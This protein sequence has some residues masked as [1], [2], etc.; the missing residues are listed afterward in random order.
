M[1]TGGIPARL[2]LSTLVTRHSCIVGSTGSGKSN[3]VAVAL[4]EL[5]DGFPSARVLVVDPHGEYGAAAGRPARVIRTGASGAENRL[6]VPYWALP[7]DELIE[8]TMGGMQPRTLCDRVREMKLEA[9]QQ[10]TDP[11]APEAITADSPVPFSIRRLWFELEDRERMTFSSRND[12]TADT[13]LDPTDPATW[14]HC[15]RLR[16]RRRRRTTRCPTG[17]KAPRE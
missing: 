1:Q 12:Q 15:D 10:L 16:I 2:Q 3:L 9:A 17:T 5:S 8:I 7:F 14:T 11:P 4:E 13:R 6:R